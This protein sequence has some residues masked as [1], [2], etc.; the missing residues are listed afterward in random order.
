MKPNISIHFLYF[1]DP[2]VPNPCKHNATCNIDYSSGNFTCQ[3]PDGWIGDI[4]N[5]GIQLLVRVNA[6]ENIFVMYFNHT[7]AMNFNIKL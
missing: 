6:L 3:C 4:C 5:I 7:I 1:T 2:C